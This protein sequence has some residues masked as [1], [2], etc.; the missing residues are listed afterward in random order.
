VSDG[1]PIVAGIVGLFLGS[2]TWAAALA[3][4]ALA[5]TGQQPDEMPLALPRW[6]P[7]WGLGLDRPAGSK[8]R[9]RP[10]IRACFEVAVAAYGMIVALRADSAGDVVALFLC[11]IPLL[12]VLL[13]DW[14]TRVIF[15]NWIAAG[16]VL[17]LVVAAF[18]GVW[19]V[20]EALA[21]LAIGAAVF[22][23]FYVLAL[24]LYRDVRVV[25]LGA[26]D[27][28]LAAMIGAMTG[29]VLAAV[30]TLFYGILLAA[31]GAGMLLLARRGTQVRALPSGAYLCAGAMI[32][33]ALQVW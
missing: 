2:I 7:L 32:G 29:D 10:P 12:V 19:S 13:V 28:W 18:D 15:T 9:G 23:A 33:L 22:G 21:G 31:I 6:L 3:Q 16:I 20:L 24:F 27:V 8:G 30:G 14:W 11:S 4:V 26:G 17:A 1:W 25:S 5:G